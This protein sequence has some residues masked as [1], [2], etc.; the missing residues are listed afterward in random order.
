MADTALTCRV[1]RVAQTA[2]LG[3]QPLPLKFKAWQVLVALLEDAPN[4]VTRERL[5]R[6]IWNGNYLTGDKGLN[7]AM[8]EI[9][10]ALA[11]DARA[12][13]YIRTIPR[14]GYRWIAPVAPDAGMAQGAREAAVA[15]HRA[16]ATDLARPAIRQ[17]SLYSHPGAALGAVCATLGLLMCAGSDHRMPAT[18]THDGEHVIPRPAAGQPMPLVH[19]SGRDIVVDLPG[20]CRRVLR[21]TEHKALSSPVLSA[22]GEHIVFELHQPSGCQLVMLDLYEGTRTDFAAC[23]TASG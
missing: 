3:G 10:G 9:R 13:E 15:H 23:P 8:W 21:P 17:R 11:D 6:D 19:R 14:T 4:T 16:H 5:I 2:T 22:D 7:Q 1:D 20:G 12:P 18:G